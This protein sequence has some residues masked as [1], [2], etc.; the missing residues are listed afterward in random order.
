ML[1]WKINLSYR[2]LESE[3]Q[4]LFFNSFKVTIKN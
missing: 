3:V 1:I 4:W 2:K